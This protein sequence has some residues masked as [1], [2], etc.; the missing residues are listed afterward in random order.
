MSQIIDALNTI[1][2][3]L[4]TLAIAVKDFISN[5]LSLMKDIGEILADTIRMLKDTLAEIKDL[6]IDKVISTVKNIFT[7]IYDTVREL[8]N[9]ITPWL[10][11]TITGVVNTT[12]N[13]IASWL[14]AGETKFI[15][16]STKAMITHIALKSIKSTIDGFTSGRIGLGGLAL[17]IVGI[18][19]L[20]ATLSKPITTLI[21]G[22]TAPVKPQPQLPVE[23]ITAITATMPSRI[24]KTLTATMRVRMGTR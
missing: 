9:M 17:R 5:F 8:F 13:L 6:T 4:K 18:P 21:T 24:G 12:V 2:D 15:T 11:Q 20:L 23:T 10:T 14:G 22:A 3:A 7:K 1:A 16:A 19:I